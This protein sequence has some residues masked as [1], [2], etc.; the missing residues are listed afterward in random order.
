MQLYL[1]A[2]KQLFS[3]VKNDIMHVSVH[4]PDFDDLGIQTAMVWEELYKIWIMARDYA[5]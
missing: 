5:C 2:S 4:I 1:L 3:I